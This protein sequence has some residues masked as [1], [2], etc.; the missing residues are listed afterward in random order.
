MQVSY[1]PF[2]EPMLV[3]DIIPGDEWTSDTEMIRIEQIEWHSQTPEMDAYVRI[4][5]Q[6]MTG[7]DRSPR[8]T[9]QWTFVVDQE[10]QIVRRPT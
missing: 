7:P 1:G 4:H 3:T 5:G 2:P 9:R 8:V 6:I 10:L